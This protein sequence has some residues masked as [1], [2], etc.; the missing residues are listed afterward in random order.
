MTGSF[1]V[2]NGNINCGQSSTINWQSTDA[3]A[4]NISGIGAVPPSGSQTVEPK[5]TTS[6]DF[7][8]S[9]P[10]GTAKGSG[11]VNVNSSLQASL[12]T[13]SPEIHY[14]RFADKVQAQES[15]TV[16]WSTTNASTVT[17]NGNNVPPSGTQTVQAAPANTAAPAEGQP[18]RTINDTRNF[19][20]RATN[21]CGGVATQNVSVRITGTIKAQPG[22][23]LQSIFYP[24]D[25]PDMK[26]P[27]VGLVK[28]QQLE[29]ATTAAGFKKY[30]EY[31][32][33][34]KLSIEAYADMR[35]SKPH[36][37][38]LSERRVERIK[39]YLVEQ[40]VPADKVETAAYGKDRPLA[41]DQ[42]A[43][44]EGSEPQM[45]PDKRFKTKT[46]KHND[47]L[48]YNRR[49]DIVLQPSGKKSSQYFPHAS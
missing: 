7:S 26:N 38:D 41:E 11:T 20:L 22:V 42:V 19:T 15:A 31:D 39:Q 6:Y 27:Q 30:L 12:S 33:D 13:S 24:T 32:P 17:L 3:V 5:T 37:Q 48:A 45:P 21:A 2:S 35:G 46:A 36:N 25:Y 18:D 40:G 1:S 28:S 34:A 47:W 29:L 4:T 49:A 16:T 43:Q 10:G 14:N 23:T 44:L 8:A 9:G